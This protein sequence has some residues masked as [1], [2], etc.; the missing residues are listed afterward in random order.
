MIGNEGQ[1]IRQPRNVRDIFIGANV[2][3]SQPSSAAQFTAAASRAWKR[4]RFLHPEVALQTAY[5][6]PEAVMRCV[7]PRDE[8]EADEWA[9]RS[10]FVCRGRNLDQGFENMKEALLTRRAAQEREESASLY[11][12]YGVDD[13]HAMVKDM[14]FVLNMDHQHTDGI[15][16]RILAGVY[17]GLLSA[18]L[19]TQ[20]AVD[21]TSI[22]WKDCIENLAPPR[23]ALMNEEQLSSGPLFEEAVRRQQQFLS[24]DLVSSRSRDQQF[25]KILP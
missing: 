13:E 4:L 20:R 22:S 16:I 24:V 7:V 2:T 6:G 14:G 18:E 21:A 9:A 15:G 10:L 25:L 11:L 3:V 1:W 23:T 19:C 17:L 5:D 8:E 12:C